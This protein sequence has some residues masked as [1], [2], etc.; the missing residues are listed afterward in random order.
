MAPDGLGVQFWI[1]IQRNW[2]NYIESDRN[3]P[4]CLFI[5]YKS[6]MYWPGIE[7][8]PARGEVSG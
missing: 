1:L 6:Y 8:G 2:W 3:L 7:P 5:D 4:L